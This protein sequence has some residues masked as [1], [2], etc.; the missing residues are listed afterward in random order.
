MKRHNWVIPAT[1]MLFLIGFSIFLA[2]RNKQDISIIK[3][4]SIPVLLLLLALIIINAVLSG[5]KISILT[6]KFGIN[7][8]P[9]EWF[10]LACINSWGNYITPFRGGMVIKGVYLKKSYGLEYS[11]FITIEGITF[12][13]SFLVVGMMGIIGILISKSPSLKLGG[14]IIFLVGLM[15]ISLIS[16][17]IPRI[18]LKSNKKFFLR[19]RALLDNWHYLKKDFS[20]ITKIVIIDMI[21]I[22]SVALRMFVAFSVL[23]I[24]PTISFCIIGAIFN[25]LSFLINL[26][27]ASLGIKEGTI[28]FLSKFWGYGARTGLYAS[29]IDRI[30]L[31]TWVATSGIFF[32]SKFLR[33]Y[34]KNKLSLNHISKKPKQDNLDSDKKQ[35][36]HQE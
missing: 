34:H 24:K 28:S 4:I 11:K 26:T 8:K 33:N 35:Q 20:L 25:H 16:M 23:N 15:A 2:L 9:A 32:S 3:S 19:L 21:I 30:V 5:L 14:I 13:A 36:E 7:L 27:P 12:I 17:N 29:I 22:I 10:G 18:N 6:K 1:M 31:M